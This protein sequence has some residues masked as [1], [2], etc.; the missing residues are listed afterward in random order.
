MGERFKYINGNY[1]IIRIIL[2]EF[3]YNFGVKK[4]FLII[5]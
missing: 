2:V 4:L 3:F 5:I 1:V